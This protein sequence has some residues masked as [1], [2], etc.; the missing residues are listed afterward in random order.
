M[1]IFFLNTLHD[2]NYKSRTFLMESV[3]LL[4]A[5]YCKPHFNKGYLRPGV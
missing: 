5:L 4:A 1:P 2:G 3:R